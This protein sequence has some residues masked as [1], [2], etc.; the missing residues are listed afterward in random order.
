MIRL[1][2]RCLLLAAAI[3]TAQAA[4]SAKAARLANTVLLDEIGVKNLRLETVEVEEQVFEETVFALGRIEVLPGR[5]SVVSSRI[6]GRAVQVKARPDHSVKAGDPLVV[7]E[8]RQAGNPPPQ[9]VLTSPMDGL[10]AELDV[11][12]GDPVNPDKA[13]LAVV[14]LS[15]VYALARV[16]VHLASR[17]RPGLRV[18]VT[19]SGWPGETWETKVEHLGALA[20][21][22]SGTLEVACHLDNQ[23]VWLRPGMP[24]E[25]HLIT[26]RRTDVMAVPRTAVQGD[27]ADRFLF[28]AHDSIPNAFV[29]VPVVVGAVNDRLAEITLGLFPGDKVVT[30]GAYSLAFAGKGSVSLKEALDAA[31]GHEHN[32]DGSERVQGQK[33]A[34]HAEDDGHDHRTQGGA[35]I[36]GLTLFSLLGN[37][38]L[39]VLLVVATVRGGPKAEAPPQNP[40][41]GGSEH[42]Q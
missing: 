39:L 11:V 7:V 26:G 20:D 8:S 2:T 27:G 1:L 12:V 41:P 13:L 21:P 31:H 19:S 22:V 34:G 42:A 18:R 5:K 16:P 17:M 37:G 40:T 4:D 14:D 15:T 25:F 6:P 36:S 28:V 33:A 3:G 38:V 10:I 29:R 24:V 30:T 23:G 32:E 35:G 9:V